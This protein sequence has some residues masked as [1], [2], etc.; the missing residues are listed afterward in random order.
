MKKEKSCYWCKYYVSSEDMCEMC[1][2]PLW[3]MDGSKF[4]RDYDDG[5]KEQE[6]K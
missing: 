4:C 1:A 3:G 6:S 2:Q 5:E